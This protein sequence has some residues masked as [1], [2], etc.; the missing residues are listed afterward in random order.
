MTIEIVKLEEKVPYR[1][2]D[3]NIGG[4]SEGKRSRERVRG[5]GLARS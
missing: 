1:E 5:Y 2:R 3:G 4:E